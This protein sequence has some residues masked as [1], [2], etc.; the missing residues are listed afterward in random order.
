ML[1]PA[2]IQQ[3]LATIKVLRW[4][5]R[6]PLNFFE[7]CAGALDRVWTFLGASCDFERNGDDEETDA[8]HTSDLDDSHDDEGE[9]VD[10]VDIKD[11]QD[12]QD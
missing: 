12:K 3:T 11:G 2:A 10:V 1:C 8:V 4:H 5:E 6:C 7:W 9:W